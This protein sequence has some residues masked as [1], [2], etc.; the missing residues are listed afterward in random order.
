MEVH[1]FLDPFEV[2]EVELPSVCPY[3]DDRIAIDE[4]NTG[5]VHNI[6]QLNPPQQV[7]LLIVINV[8]EIV[9]G[10]RDEDIMVDRQFYDMDLFFIEVTVENRPQRFVYVFA[11]FVGFLVLFVDGEVFHEV[12]GEH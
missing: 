4:G 5:G 3:D 10:G 2:D 8:E 12:G 6:I 9:V 11:S 7:N 1:F